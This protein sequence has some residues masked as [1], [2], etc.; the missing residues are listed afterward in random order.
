MEKK[1]RYI[2]ILA[3]LIV[4]IG[5]IVIAMPLLRHEEGVNNINI[6]D[7]FEAENFIRALDEKGEKFAKCDGKMIGAVV[8]HHM[9]G[10]QFIAD[11]F[12]Q[13]K[14]VDTVLVIGPN[15]WEKGSSSIITSDSN[16]VTAKGRVPVDMN[17]VNGLR[18]NEIATAE[19]D[20]IG[21]DH[22]IGNILPFIAYYLPSASVVPI[23]FKKNISQDKLEK[24]LYYIANQKSNKILVVGSVDFSHYLTAQQSEK[25]DAITIK[26]ILDKDYSKISG[27]DN[28]NLDS[29]LTLNTLLKATDMLGS[30]RLLWRNSNSFKVLNGDINNTTSYFELVFCRNE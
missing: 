14:D 18:S 20:V 17:F 6:T 16:W 27:F 26:A 3:I 13:A 2:V 30:N 4:I 24:L 29:P 5:G 11:V 7:K 12:S 9:V 22:S 19:N 25:K 8:P 23:I 10:G 1:A 21:N 28:D 15:H